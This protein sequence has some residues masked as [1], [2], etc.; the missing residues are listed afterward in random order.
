MEDQNKSEF[1]FGVKRPETI[2]GEAYD[3][4]KDIEDNNYKNVKSYEGILNPYNEYIIGN[5]Y[6]DLVKSLVDSG[7]STSLNINDEYSDPETGRIAKDTPYFDDVHGYR[8][9]FHKDKDGN[10]VISASDLYDFGKNY[11][12]SFQDLNI[13]RGGDGNIE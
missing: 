5:K 12:E 4:A 8:I 7:Y 11:T 3:W 10:P 1:I 6:K 13:E 2:D 9:R